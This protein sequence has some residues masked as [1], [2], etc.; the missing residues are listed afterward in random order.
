MTFDFKQSKYK[1][2]G[3]LLDKF[4][5]DKAGGAGV[6]TQKV[7]R[8]QDHISAV[9]RSHPAYLAAAPAAGGGEAGSPSTTQVRASFCVPSELA[10]R[11]SGRPAVCPTG[12][13]AAARLSHPEWAATDA[14]RGP[15]S[16]PPPL[17]SAGGA[18]QVG[19][20]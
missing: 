4:E 18:L 6:L 13:H 8:K 9:N 15:A 5:K 1:K 14:C 7:I 19:S 12:Q 10:C 17:P 11:T 16:R 20:Q 2:L 3:K